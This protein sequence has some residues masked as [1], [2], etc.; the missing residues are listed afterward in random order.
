MLVDLATQAMW[1]SHQADALFE[2]GRKRAR[3]IVMAT[4]AMARNAALGSRLRR[5]GAFRSPMA[6]AVIGGL[7]VSTVPS[8]IVVSAAFTLLD[9]GGRLA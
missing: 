3:T 1:R 2:A 8:Q 7:V 6:I 5:G 9:D 4:V